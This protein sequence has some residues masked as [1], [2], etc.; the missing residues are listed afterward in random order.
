MTRSLFELVEDYIDLRRSLGYKLRGQDRYLRGFARFVNRLGHHGPVPLEVSVAWANSTSSTDACHSA[1]RLT[2]VRGFLR[3]LAAIDTA[4]DVPPPGLLGPTT[5]RKP[6][7]IYS[8]AEIASLLQAAAALSPHAGLRPHCY[9]TLFA[10]LACTG[11]RIS[12]ALALNR[13]D[14]DLLDGIL[15]VRHGKGDRMRIVPLHP[16]A[17]SPMRDYASRRDHWRGSRMRGAFFR[18]ERTE[19]L[20]YTAVR[21]TF[22]SLRLRLGWTA[23]GRARI[24][25]LHDLRHW[26][27]VHR[28][29]LW[30]SQDIDVDRKIA[31][32]ATYLGHVVISDVYWYFSAAPELMSVVAHRFE[33]FSQPTDQEAHHESC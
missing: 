18:T 30:Y 26:M 1:R 13:E 27:V 3:Y 19:R 17:L 29:L 15:T 22:Q 16:S 12:E 8:D 25:R 24:P 31:A 9:A 7:H 4:T 14:V 20:T 6:P 28:L 5:R 10:L 32:L 2:I 11:L 21:N 33:R 23:Q